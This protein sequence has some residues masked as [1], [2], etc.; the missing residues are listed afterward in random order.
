MLGVRR[1][2]WFSTPTSLS[3]RFERL[4]YEALEGAKRKRS[5]RSRL[6]RPA[7][8]STTTS[9]STYLCS[10]IIVPGQLILHAVFSALRRRSCGPYP[11]RTYGDPVR[12]DTRGPRRGLDGR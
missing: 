2:T 3:H 10:P 5:S 1:G 6:V 12:P 4:A 11:W 8:T 7:E 9:S